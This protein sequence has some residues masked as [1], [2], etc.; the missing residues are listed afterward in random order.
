MGVTP[1]MRTQWIRYRGVALQESIHSAFTAGVL[2]NL[3]RTVQAL[4][5]WPEHNPFCLWECKSWS[6][7]NTSDLELG[8]SFRAYHSFF[9]TTDTMN[10]GASALHCPKAPLLQIR[11][12]CLLQGMNPCLSPALQPSSVLSGFV[13]KGMWFSPTESV[14][15]FV[16]MAGVHLKWFRGF[17]EVTPSYF[18]VHCLLCRALINGSY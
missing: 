6:I 7:F 11:R 14:S 13:T 18:S 4:C 1:G 8:I 3:H 5:L 15:L 17:R 16:Q 9:P 10:S 12:R 2:V